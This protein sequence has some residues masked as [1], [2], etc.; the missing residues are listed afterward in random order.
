MWG[1]PPA[2]SS[3]S[4][5]QSLPAASSSQ[6]TI[7][8][9][10]PPF[11]APGG[12]DAALPTGPPPHRT[13]AS[14]AP[15]DDARARKRSELECTESH[16]S[17]RGNRPQPSAYPRLQNS[18]NS[19]CDGVSPSCPGAVQCPLHPHPSGRRDACSHVPFSNF[20]VG[21]KNGHATSQPRNKPM[22]RTN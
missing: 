20:S 9:N 4:Q 14:R 13:P 21:I 8:E 18:R 3:N 2:V 11:A 5:L 16:A 19:S 10:I 7:P 6:C 17:S 22:K 1:Q 12:R 15:R